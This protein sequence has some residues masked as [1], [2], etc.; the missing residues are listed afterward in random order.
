MDFDYL[1]EK[2]DR[3]LAILESGEA[4]PIRRADP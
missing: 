2:L 1:E 4:H 3:L